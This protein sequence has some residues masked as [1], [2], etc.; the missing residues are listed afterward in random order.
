MIEY[1]CPKC[2]V[3]MT[4]PDSM[5]RQPETCLACGN[6]TIVPEPGISIEQKSSPT[7]S[8]PLNS[9]Q[10]VPA[11]SMHRQRIAVVCA[12]GFGMAATFLPW[13]K[14]PIIGSV[15]GT[16]WC[17]WCTLALFALSLLIAFL[18]HR[19]LPFRTAQLVG[20]VL[21]AILAAVAAISTVPDIME[22]M[23]DAPD[24]DLFAWAPGHM[25]QIGFGFYLV[26][27]AAIALVILS[28]ALRGKPTR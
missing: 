18:G 27:I 23:A 24:N 1:L 17:G 22:D 28:V 13:A 5:A 26:I 16:V 12:A 9:A 21:P 14:A 20:A 25:T 3:G 8:V 19:E 11:A 10:I 15:D 4:S 7:S 2:R 6:V